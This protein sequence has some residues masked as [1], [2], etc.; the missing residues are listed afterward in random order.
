MAEQ[1]A[2]GYTATEPATAESALDQEEGEDADLA[3]FAGAV[4]PGSDKNNSSG[5][6]RSLSRVIY[7]DAKQRCFC[8]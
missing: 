4:Y 8:C 2:C 6:T 3:L 7:D 5:P 1:E